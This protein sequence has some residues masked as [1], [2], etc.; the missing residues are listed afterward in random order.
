VRSIAAFLASQIVSE[1]T[2]RFDPSL[3][4]SD[5]AMAKQSRTALT[6]L[7]ANKNYASLKGHVENAVGFVMRHEHTAKDVVPFIKELALTLYNSDYI[8]AS[9]RE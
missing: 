4:L 2:L 1:T 6:S 5:L 8:L 9:L 7:R 3:P